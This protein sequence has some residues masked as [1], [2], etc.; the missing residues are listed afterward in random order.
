M[1]AGRSENIVFS[2]L[3][4]IL[5]HCPQG[6]AAT[7]DITYSVAV[8]GSLREK[9]PAHGLDAK[10]FMSGRYL[11]GKLYWCIASGFKLLIPLCCSAQQVELFE[12]SL[13]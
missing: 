2:Q 7:M 8:A 13:F 5:N 3:Q 10:S 1:A 6:T 11:T 9:R 12:D 4:H